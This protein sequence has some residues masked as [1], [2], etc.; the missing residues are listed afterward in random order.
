MKT[1]YIESLGCAKNLVDSEVFAFILDEAGW[2]EAEIPEEADLVL[3]NTCSFL[4]E[5]LQEL[6][7]V[8]SDLAYLKQQH[9]TGK[10]VV[11]GCVMKRGLETFRRLYPEVDEWI[12]LKDFEAFSKWLGLEIPVPAGRIPIQSGYHRYLRI[13]DG[14]DND[15]SYCAIP[16]I[17]GRMRCVP[18]EQLVQE[19]E[20]IASDDGWQFQELVVIAQDTA[21]YGMDIYGRKALPELLERL[22][23]LPQYRWIRVMYMHPDHFEPSWLKLWKEHKKLL[24]YFEIPVQH[25]VEHI[26]RSMNRKRKG[27]ELVEMFDTILEEI[28]GSVLR[29]TLISGFPS[30]TSSD[31][32][33]LRE[34]IERVPFL[35]LGVF[36][37]SPEEGTP[38]ARMPR[39][40]A[41]ATA[42]RRRNRLLKR[43]QERMRQLLEDYVGRTVDVLIEERSD[44][45]DDVFIGRAWFQAPEIDGVTIVRGD[46]IHVGEIRPVKITD[47]IDADL[48]GEVFSE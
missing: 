16:S 4:E 21:N 47:V 7:M 48:F 17:R 39:Q 15:C 13:S 31:A 14:C 9:L 41:P 19:A 10:L 3:V 24:P 18:I 26:L 20:L 43:Q 12:G 23:A 35:H 45:E 46:G 2:E 6:D 5:A 32:V 37:Y 25:S 38:A 28:P 44:D 8:L 42:E 27:D 36:L 34:F 40:V 30:E 33:A 11:T 29:T 1:Y 22:S